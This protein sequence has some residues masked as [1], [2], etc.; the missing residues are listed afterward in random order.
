MIQA[1]LC[2][3]T[4]VLIRVLL[5]LVLQLVPKHEYRHFCIKKDEEA[6]PMF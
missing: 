2:T 3:Q 4:F 5:L 6:E 1:E